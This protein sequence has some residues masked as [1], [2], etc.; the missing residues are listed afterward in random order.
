[1]G[2]NRVDV[3][4]SLYICICFLL[5]STPMYK[6][7]VS[8]GT[9]PDSRGGVLYMNVV[10]IVERLVWNNVDEVMNHKPGIC[11]CEKCRADIVAYALNHLTPRYVVSQKGEVLAKAASLGQAYH[12][13]LLVA[14]AE[15]VE[16]V[17][18]HPR[19]E[20]INL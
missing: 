17:S 1:M 5:E 8:Q 11:H 9:T 15:A 10:N 20:D 18:A 13:A 19:H 3:S 16:V 12:T 14:L 2:G 6:E 7:K 4:R